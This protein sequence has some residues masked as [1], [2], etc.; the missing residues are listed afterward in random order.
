[1]QAGL[2]VPLVRATRGVLRSEKLRYERLLAE[3]WGACDA[4]D[5][6]GDAALAARYEE[7]FLLRLGEY[8]ALC[9]HLA[10]RG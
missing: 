7:R 9:D 2:P 4:M 5:R 10:A 3:A 1:M 6:S 8:E